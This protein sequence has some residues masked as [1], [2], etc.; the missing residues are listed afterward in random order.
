MDISSRLRMLSAVVKVE[1]R[2]MVG[3]ALPVTRWR[4][5]LWGDD[6]RIGLCFRRRDPRHV[7]KKVELDRAA[8]F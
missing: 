7:R 2:R 3:R 1:R 8:P 5:G 6:C 4:P